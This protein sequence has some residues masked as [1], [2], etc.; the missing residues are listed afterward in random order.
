MCGRGLSASGC[1]SAISIIPLSDRRSRR[2]LGLDWIA[3]PQEAFV[4]VFAHEHRH[5]AQWREAWLPL[6]TIK[7]ER[8]ADA[9]G[10]AAIAAYRSRWR[11]PVALGA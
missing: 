10:R 7:R 11:T 8:D 9:T 4:G 1:R 6:S 5:L 3:T 2:I